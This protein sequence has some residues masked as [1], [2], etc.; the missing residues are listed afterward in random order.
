M[1]VKYGLTIYDN[2]RVKCKRCGYTWE[3]NKE[4][5]TELKAG[6]RLSCLHCRAMNELKPGELVPKN[7]QYKI[8]SSVSAKNPDDLRGDNYQDKEIDVIHM[9]CKNSFK[10][11]LIDIR[12]GNIKCPFCAS[13]KR[14][15][16]NGNR[17]DNADRTSNI[18]KVPTEVVTK[19]DDLEDITRTPLAKDD[20]KLGKV[21]R[22]SVRIMSI[23]PDTDTYVIQCVKC[24]AEETR[25]LQ[26]LKSTTPRDKL[27]Y[28]SRC[29]EKEV[30]LADLRQEYI[31]KVFNGQI[32][33]DIYADDNGYTVCDLACT[34]NSSNGTL[35]TYVTALNNKISSSS[36]ISYK[37]VEDIHTQKR[38][39]FGDVINKRNFCPICGDTSIKEIPKI[40]NKLVCP[41]FQLYKHNGIKKDMEVADLKLKDFY[42]GL[43]KSLC[44]FCPAKEKC[45]EAGKHIENTMIF[46]A[47][48][49]DMEDSL[50]ADMIG[51]A[52]KFPTAFKFTESDSK[53]LNILPDKELIVFKD[54]FVDEDGKVYKLC[55]CRRHGTELTLNDSEI[56]D[57]KHEQCMQNNP[58][59]RFFNL[60]SQ[61]YLLDKHNKD[62]GSKK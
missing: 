39:P 53:H 57:F 37:A 43:S 20:K 62:K 14:V 5:Q 58:Y 31:G 26:V 47:T 46:I 6:H 29:K 13:A 25:S 42:S 38:V 32:I 9:R 50:I 36:K 24:G 30:D 22:N 51:I 18:G 49:I 17:I 12:Q 33:E 55:K 7:T 1:P 28:C 60:P 61:I 45:P 11:K 2:Y 34:R 16:T 48:S 27:L 59:M 40:R 35:D 56:A 10:A 23:D 52:E 4:E 8:G 15:D 3:P 19:S 54:A 41:L 21:L 44:D